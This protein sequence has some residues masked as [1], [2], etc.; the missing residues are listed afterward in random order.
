MRTHFILY[1]ACQDCSSAF[2][3]RVLGIPPMFNVPGMTEFELGPDTILGLMP[4]IG[5]VGLL[6]EAIGDPRG[7]RS[8]PRCEVYLMVSNVREYL[9][10][11]LGAGARELSGIKLRDWG[12]IATYVADPDGHVIAFARQDQVR[13]TVSSEGDTSPEGGRAS[14][15]S[16][17]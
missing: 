16:G 5:I 2:Y 14:S 8:A 3:Q 9:D 10:R 1:V 7:A 4:E 6:G 12:H 13:S 15:K 11:A 17:R